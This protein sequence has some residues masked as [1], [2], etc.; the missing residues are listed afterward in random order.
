VEKRAHAGCTW[1]VDQL[2]AIREFE[3]KIIAAF[4]GADQRCSM[5]LR[6]RLAELNRWID[7]LDRAV[8]DYSPAHASAHI[9]AQA[10]QPVARIEPRS[11][12]QVEQWPV[13]RIEH[14]SRGFAA[15][16]R[17]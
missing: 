16:A 1:I 13:S 15:A 8:E 7:K 4:Q 5:Q 11:V 14:R 17:H 3:E 10:D 12:S 6:F 9:L 2:I